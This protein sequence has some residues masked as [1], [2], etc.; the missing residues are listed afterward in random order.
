MDEVK[1]FWTKANLPIRDLQRCVEKVEKLYEEYRKIQKNSNS[2]VEPQVK[3]GNDFLQ[4]LKKIFE[5]APQLV[6]G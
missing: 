6:L 4:K 2:R 5:I 3:K 1:V